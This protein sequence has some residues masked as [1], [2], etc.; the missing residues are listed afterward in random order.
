MGTHVSIPATVCYEGEGGE[1]YRYLV[2]FI[3]L[4]FKVFLLSK[5]SGEEK[6]TMELF[7]MQTKMKGIP[8]CCIRDGFNF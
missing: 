1:N 8:K 3:T 4:I 7:S 6:H 5:F 2:K